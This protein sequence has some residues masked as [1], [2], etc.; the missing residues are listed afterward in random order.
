MLLKLVL[1][2]IFALISAQKL[3]YDDH[4]LYKIIPQNEDHIQFLKDLERNDK[5]LDFW[6]SPARVGEY[7]S[8]VAPPNKKADLEHTLK[9]RSIQNEVMLDNIQE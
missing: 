7:V 3:R 4:A 2:S 8:V 9:K 1:F 5:Y 6:N